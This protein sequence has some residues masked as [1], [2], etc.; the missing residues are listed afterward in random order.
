LRLAWFAAVAIFAIFG[1]AEFG[2]WITES[3]RG[4]SWWATD[5]DLLPDADARSASG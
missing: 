2:R 5:L 4:P 1:A 3:L